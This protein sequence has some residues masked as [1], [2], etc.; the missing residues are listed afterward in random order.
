LNLFLILSPFFLTHFPEKCDIAAIKYKRKYGTSI[1]LIIHDMTILAEVV[2]RLAIMYAG[3]IIEVD[4]VISIF[5]DPL[6]PY[7]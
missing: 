2:D 5:K 7:T 3:K 6:H 1:I 4:D